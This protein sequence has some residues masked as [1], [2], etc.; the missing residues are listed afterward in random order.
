MKFLFKTKNYLQNQLWTQEPAPTGS[1]KAMGIRLIRF[2]H[3][4]FLAFTD[5]QLALQASSLVYTTLLSLIPLLAVSFSMLK[6]FGVHNMFEDFLV[7]FLAP[8]GPE[9]KDLAMQTTE[10]VDRLNAGVLGSIGLVFLLYKAIS[11]MYELEITLNHIWAV[12][13]SKSLGRRF[14]NYL[15]VLLVG[16][17]L[18]LT[19]TGIT[20][21][22]M[23]TSFIV[24][25]QQFEP[26]G[27][28][29]FIIGE[30]LPYVMA[31]AAFALVYKFLPNRKVY[32]LSALMGGIFAGILW[33]LAG[34]AF[35]AFTV[36]SSQYSAV[37]SGFAFPILFLIWLQLSWTILL[38]GAK[39]SFHHQYPGPPPDQKS[40]ALGSHENEKIA[41]LI[42]F[43]VTKNFQ[44]RKPLN[45]EYIVEHLGL[46]LAAV[47]TVLARLV[48]KR[49][50]LEVT[51]DPPNYV[52]AVDPDNL[53]LRE[54][55]DALGKGRKTA[56]AKVP[57]VDALMAR[58][59][60]CSSASLGAM[61][62]KDLT[63]HSVPEI[64]SM[65]GQTSD[66]DTP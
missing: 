49:L 32:F 61:T 1:L 43:L 39:L 10:Y 17:V 15:S 47:Q 63:T 16:P 36:T 29:I 27:A 51:Q 30:L 59:D 7:G 23:S 8:L 38:V 20:V 55:L 65:I 62:I 19:A 50:L 54:I 64:M 3:L 44:L 60:A 33:Q 52:P 12:E 14:A 11:L 35:A 46:P 28:T 9:G 26:V 31:I 4:V 40:R 48:H 37:Y 53:T 66:S 6:A 25:V 2:F 42:M 22:F 56:Y 34:L 18:V 57:E 5:R 41:L 13:N 24:W 21:S 45:L 58:M